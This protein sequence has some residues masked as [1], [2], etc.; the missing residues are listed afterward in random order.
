MAQV[1]QEG[2]GAKVER[3]L[4]TTTIM[5][6][7]LD[8]V[9]G[10]AG[11]MFIAA[12][13]NA[14]PKHE[15]NFLEALRRLELPGV[16]AC[17]LDSRLSHGLQGSGF[18]VETADSGRHGDGDGAHGHLP[19][20]TIKRLIET[21]RLEKGA[22]A[23]A[24][25]IFQL[26]AEAEA[27]VHGITP[28]EVEF[29]EVGATDSIVDIIGAGLLIDCL[30]A[31][32]WTIAPLPTGSGQVRSAHGWLPVPAPA[33]AL[34]LEG[35]LL[36][37]DGIPGERVTPTGAAIVRYLGCKPIGKQPARRLLA[38][39]IGLGTKSFPG[40]SN[41]L[42]VLAFDPPT[43]GVGAH[44]HFPEAD[45][46]GPLLNQAAQTAPA[47]WAENSLSGEGRSM[48]SD[49]VLMLEFEVDDQSSEDLALGLD[50]LRDAPGVLDVSQ[51][52]LT[53]KRGRQMAHI[54]VLT[55]PDQ[56]EAVA[57]RCF[58][59][60]TTIGLRVSAV[61]R[62]I[63]PRQMLETSV[64]GWPVR[65]KVVHR[66]GLGPSAK[67]ES[68]DLAVV[69]GGQVARSRVRE[70]AARQ[71][72]QTGHLDGGRPTEDRFARPEEQRLWTKD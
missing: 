54:Q 15:T 63:L 69:P 43:I 26:L 17:R 30:A 39:G 23:H 21:A 56:V 62:W 36:R 13:L 44:A 1:A 40:L 14:F 46:I 29:H 22:I 58:Q 64:E 18:M 70:T 50:R 19:W 41:C 8:P 20:K 11:D 42:R 28:D 32:A 68:Q 24:V 16:K 48:E 25:G 59:E 6:L 38:T 33:T 71:A 7:H 9:G 72:L 65:V 55:V 3:A 31:D 66:P 47:Q 2:N 52:T 12:L 61:R 27:K 37:D 35:F 4:R 51:G 53:G 67:A 34:L 5:E 57:E 45:R 10:I 49:E 60:T